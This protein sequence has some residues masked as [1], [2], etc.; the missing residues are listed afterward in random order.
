MLSSLSLALVG[1]FTIEF[2]LIHTLVSLGYFL[3]APIGLLLIGFGVNDHKLRKLS[4]ITGPLAIIAIL[5]LPIILMILPFESGF[6][7]PEIIHSLILGIWT[8]S[9]SHN[10]LFPK[11]QSNNLEA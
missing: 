4:L 9:I 7:I 8:I 11:N 6:A 2:S 1:I 5:I 10:M 3:L